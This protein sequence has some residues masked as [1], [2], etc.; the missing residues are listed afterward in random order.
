[1]CPDE[2]TNLPLSERRNEYRDRPLTEAE[3]GD[4]P[5]ALFDRWLREAIEI[6]EGPWFEPNAM[7][8][9][10]ADENGRPDARIVL[11][12][13]C[14]EKGFSFYTNCRSR[15][16]QHLHENPRAAMV[17]YWGS[18]ER[19]VRVQGRVKPLDA[20]TAAEYFARRPRG[21]QL[22][23]HASLQSQPIDSREVLEKRL[24]AVEARFEG[25][26]V[27]LPDHWGGYCLTP[28]EIEFW[29]GRP[30]R[31]HDRIRFYRIVD[32]KWR[33]QRLSP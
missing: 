14:S 26:D 8:L 12:K 28:E 24:A 30:N 23:A 2:Q 6:N 13:D 3:A 27:P 4:D 5:L 9:A 29:Q 33:R 32:G 1:M 17:F 11:L 15:K 21:S 20:G 7:T 19:Q 25:R 22:G 10:T 31:L 16:A 18:L